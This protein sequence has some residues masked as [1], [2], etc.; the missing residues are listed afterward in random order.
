MGVLTVRG[1]DE[2]LGVALKA[3][4]AERGVSVNALVLQLLRE[5]LGLD[6]SRPAKPRIYHDLDGFIGSIT[7]EEA[8]E[9]L[10]IIEEECGRVDEEEWR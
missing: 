7:D 5:S 4:A 6:E 10:R 3:E 9:M 1:V 8:E 2:Q